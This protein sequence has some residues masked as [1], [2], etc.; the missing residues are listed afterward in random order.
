MVWG[1]RIFLTTDVEAGKAEGNQPPKHVLRGTPFRHPDS[2]G[3]DVRHKFALL[4]LDR[5]TGKILWQRIH[6]CPVKYFS[7]N[8]KYRSL[9]GMA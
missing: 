2:V 8:Y 9:S 3:A 4:C 7:T 6:Y 5:K 1:D